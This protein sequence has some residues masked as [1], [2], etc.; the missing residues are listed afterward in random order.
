MQSTGL[1]STHRP[2]QIALWNQNRCS[3]TAGR[4]PIIKDLEK[5]VAVFLKWWDTINPSWRIRINGCLKI[6]GAG[7]WV[8]LHK[9]GQNGFLSV[10]QILSWWRERLGV[11]A[12][13]DWN[14]AVEDVLWV[15][16]G[17]LQSVLSTQ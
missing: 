17:V 15:L 12:V 4:Q 10:L 6:G 8:S 14:S 5:F 7:P 9:P 1:P 11:E 13:E 16:K 2:E 3:L